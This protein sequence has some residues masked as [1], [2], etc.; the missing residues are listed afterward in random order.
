MQAQT[1]QPPQ[2]AITGQGIRNWGSLI[3]WALGAAFALCV[4]LVVYSSAGT[5]KYLTITN[6]LDKHERELSELTKKAALLDNVKVDQKE[7]QVAVAKIDKVAEGMP[8]LQSSLNSVLQT[9]RE[10]QMQQDEE[11]KRRGGR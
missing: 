2:G 7:F 8:V 1:Y 3:T 4:G 11:R 5:E 6:Q 10:M 9:V